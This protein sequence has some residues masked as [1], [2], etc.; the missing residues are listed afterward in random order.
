[1]CVPGLLLAKDRVLDGLDDAE[2]IVAALRLHVNDVLGSA[3]V[4][5]DIKLVDFDLPIV[6][7]LRSKMVLQR[8]GGDAENVSTRRL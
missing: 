6:V 8:V 1:M 2:D 4:Y 7:D 5:A 3:R